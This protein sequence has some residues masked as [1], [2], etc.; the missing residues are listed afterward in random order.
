MKDHIV[1]YSSGTKFF[2]W[3]VAFIV[4]G[5]LAVSFFL[6]DLSAQYKPLAYLLHKSFGLTVLFTMIVRLI[7]ISYTGKPELPTTIPLWEKRLSRFVQ[8]S[9]YLFV[10]LLPLCGWIMS[11]AADR[12]P[13]YFGLFHLSFPGISPNKELASLMLQAHRTIAWVVIGLLILHVAG[14]LKH[15]FIDKD[16]VLLSM[17]PKH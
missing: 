2:H 14:A 16:S 8:Y 12:P 3:F 10:I 9:L 7:W 6:D 15:H 5:M 17:L 13:Y 11:V 1:C 4:I